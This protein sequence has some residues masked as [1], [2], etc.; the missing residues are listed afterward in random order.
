MISN[1]RGVFAEKDEFRVGPR[2]DEDDPSLACEEDNVLQIEDD[3]LG[4][5]AVSD[6]II[7]GVGEVFPCTFCL[8]AS[9]THCAKCY[10][11]LCLHH[12]QLPCSICYDGSDIEDDPSPMREEDDHNWP[13][14]D[15]VLETS[16]ILC[17]YA[18]P[19]SEPAPLPPG[20]A[21]AEPRKLVC[22]IP[23]M[24]LHEVIT[25]PTPTVAVDARVVVDT[26]SLASEAA[27]L[28]PRINLTELRAQGTPI[29]SPSCEEDDH[30]WPHSEAAAS[31]AAA[32]RLPSADAFVRAVATDNFAS[33]VFEERALQEI[34]FAFVGAYDDA[35]CAPPP[36]SKKKRY[37][38]KRKPR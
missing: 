17:A 21:S 37:K 19:C 6:E 22:K 18:E 2:V 12:A 25:V 35:S 15:A 9:F 29:P 16:G 32:A 23:K 3:L 7:A 13:P 1:P 34:I 31:D 11:L 33:L 20:I 28:T 10:S 24:P 36:D 4:D 30:N 26:S 27:V 5:Q 8:Q 38:G 14:M